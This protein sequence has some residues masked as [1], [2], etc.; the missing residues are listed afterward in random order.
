MTLKFGSQIGAEMY[1]FDDARGFVVVL[2]RFGTDKSGEVEDKLMNPNEEGGVL[3]M[4]GQPTDGPRDLNSGNVAGVKG[5][6]AADQDIE[7]AAR[8]GGS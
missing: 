4:G 1:A 8:K 7:Q 5:A 2:M 3:G 6:G